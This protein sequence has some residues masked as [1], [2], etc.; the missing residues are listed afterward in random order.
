M[1]DLER[2]VTR[3]RRGRVENPLEV[4][5]QLDRIKVSSAGQDR[6]SFRRRVHVEP[7]LHL[8]PALASATL[9]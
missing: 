4:G 6:L 5:A 2:Q 1:R 7:T 3:S 9:F 8:S